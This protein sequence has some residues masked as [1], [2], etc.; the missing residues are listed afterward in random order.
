MKERKYT[1]RDKNNDVV[2]GLENISIHNGCLMHLIA[3]GADIPTGEAN[4]FHNAFVTYFYDGRG[5]SKTEYRIVLER[6]F[7]E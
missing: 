7:V 1:I 2:L 6:E 4:K 3:K 5:A